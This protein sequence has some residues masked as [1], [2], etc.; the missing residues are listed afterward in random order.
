MDRNRELRTETE[1]REKQGIKERSRDAGNGNEGWECWQS[2]QS[3]QKGMEHD[4][5][6][7]NVMEDLEWC[8]NDVRASEMDL[9]KFYVTSNM[10]HPSACSII[11][12]RGILTCFFI[13]GKT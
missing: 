10:N 8:R 5:R 1:Y 12:C 9:V 3:E 7:W 4:G 13:K 2:E 11:F 6:V